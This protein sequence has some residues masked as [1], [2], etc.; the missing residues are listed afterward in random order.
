MPHTNTVNPIFSRR[1]VRNSWT[2][3]ATPKGGCSQSLFQLL[4]CSRLSKLISTFVKPL[5]N[6]KKECGKVIDSHYP[7]PSLQNSQGSEVEEVMEQ[8]LTLSSSSWEP[9][10]LLCLFFK[11]LVG[12]LHFSLQRPFFDHLR[13]PNPKQSQKKKI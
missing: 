2:I 6:K 9:F 13:F 8:V 10:L 4:P 5:S 11:P 3:G 12:V 7:P 1:L